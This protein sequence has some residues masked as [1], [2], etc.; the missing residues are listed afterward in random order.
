[1]PDV[2]IQQAVRI[3]EPAPKRRRYEQ[4]QGAQALES[5]TQYQTVWSH[6]A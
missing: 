2:I 5:Y 4:K 6:L 3:S 1:M